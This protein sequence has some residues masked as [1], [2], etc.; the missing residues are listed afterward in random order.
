MNIFYTDGN[1]TIAARNLCNKHV[2]KMATES[3]Q[4]LSTLLP[5]DIAPFKHTHYN[6]PCCIWARKNSTHALWLLLH[7]QGI[8]LEYTRRYG[9]QHGSF[10]GLQC[11]ELYE[12]VK[13]MPSSK[14]EPPPQ[15]MPE[16]YRCSDTILAYRRYYIGDKARF[17]K[18]MCIS[19]I[20]SW[21]PVLS[22]EFVSKRKNPLFLTLEQIAA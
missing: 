1:P 12:F 20:P 15:C 9:K 11:P 2:V 3:V 7:A 18:W 13:T 21:W 17:A 6:H 14:F 10:R 16:E 19:E 8:F 22:D 4:I 5:P